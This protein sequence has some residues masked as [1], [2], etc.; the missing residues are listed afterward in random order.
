MNFFA[1]MGAITA[2]FIVPVPIFLDPCTP[3]VPF[4]A[5]SR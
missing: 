3:L 2:R 1:L 4:T 5:T